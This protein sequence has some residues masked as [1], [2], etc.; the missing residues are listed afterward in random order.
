MGDAAD[1]NDATTTTHDGHVAPTATAPLHAASSSPSQH[2]DEQPK[3]CATT[4]P[5]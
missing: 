3:Q 5:A 1:G 4:C 2:D